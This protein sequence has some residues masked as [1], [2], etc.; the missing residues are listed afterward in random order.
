MITFT[1][2]PYIED[3]PLKASTV[4]TSIALFNQITVPLYIVPLVIPMLISAIVSNR[5]LT[6]YFSMRN[7]QSNI[8]EWNDQQS[9]YYNNDL[10]MMDAPRSAP[11]LESELSS[12]SLTMNNTK[13]L[14]R[15]LDRCLSV[16]SS[17]RPLSKQNNKQFENF[18]CYIKNG[19]F[20]WYDDD[21]AIRAN[22][23]NPDSIECTLSDI[24]VRF[25]RNRLTILVGSIGSGKS[26][27]LASMIGETYKANGEIHWLDENR[28][29]FGYVPS[30]AWIL[31]VSL[32]DNIIFGR[33]FESKRYDE[34]IC[35]CCLKADID[36]LPY[37]DLTIIGERGITLSGGQ[38]QRIALARA[39][40]SSAST[41][42]LDDSLSALDPIVGYSV[43][44]NAIIVSNK[45]FFPSG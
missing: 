2:Y 11:I 43:F 16:A 28:I 8:I 19:K 44:E 39:L 9:I 17:Y 12:S 35:A 37:G 15:T 29:S 21:E 27:L 7:I 3:Q 26:T 31:N 36:L 22:I 13:F 18:C 23:K 25:P 45:L 41:L 42:I 40:Y 20:I 34:I 5:R 38:R 10:S 33:T 32:R 24:N 6:N 30:M 14:H 1:M 4:F